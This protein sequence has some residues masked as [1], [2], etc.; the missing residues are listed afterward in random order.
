MA[1]IARRGRCKVLRYAGAQPPMIAKRPIRLQLCGHAR[2]SRTDA[3]LGRG[4][5]RYLDT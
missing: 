4:K 3:S 2:P 5:A 1:L